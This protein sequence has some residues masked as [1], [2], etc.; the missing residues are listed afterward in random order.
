MHCSFLRDYQGPIMCGVDASCRVV[1]ADCDLRNGMGIH[2]RLTNGGTGA[3]RGHA[4]FN[5]NHRD[6][7]SR[8]GTCGN[9]THAFRKIKIYT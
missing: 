5:F 4:K 6:Y 1:P 2:T 3:L 9:E 7:C 8:V